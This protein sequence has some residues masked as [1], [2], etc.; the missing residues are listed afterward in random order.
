[1]WSVNPVFTPQM[2]PFNPTPSQMV[3]VATAVS[4]VGIPTSLAALLSSGATV[5]GVRAEARADDFSLDEVGEFV[6]TTPAP[7][8]GAP[9]KPNQSSVVFSL[10]TD[11]VGARARGRMYW[12]ALAATL[13]ATTG[14]MTSPVPATVATEASTYLRN[15]A[16][17]VAS[18]LTGVDT[19]QPCVFSRVSASNRFVTGVWVGDVLDTQR[20][21]RD[22][23]PETYA[24]AVYPPP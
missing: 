24:R 12:P 23:L 16:T 3:A 20:R 11:G 4:G 15:I 19:W 6:R 10:R 18:V 2:P 9:N 1:M 14:R 13:S 8:S 7:G 5:T 22:K 21:R 17:A